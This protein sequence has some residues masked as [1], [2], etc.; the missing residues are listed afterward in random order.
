MSFLGFILRALALTPIVFL[1]YLPV[2][3]T[4]KVLMAAPRSGVQADGTRSA[5]QLIAVE[6]SRW[7]SHARS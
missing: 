5:R 7:S 2:L 1:R 6:A 3:A 4:T